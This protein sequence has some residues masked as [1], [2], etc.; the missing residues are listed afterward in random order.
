MSAVERGEVDRLL[1]FSDRAAHADQHGAGDD[2]VT[3]VQL[4]QILEARHGSYIQR[5]E[6]VT[7]V[8]LQ[9]GIAHSRGGALERCECLGRLR[10]V[11][12][13]PVRMKRMGPG[14]RVELADPGARLL[15]RLDLARI[16]IDEHAHGNPCVGKSADH[17]ADAADG[18]GDI[19]AAFGRDLGPALRHQ[20]GRVRFHF[21]GDPDHLVGGRH[22]QVEAPAHGVAQPMHIEILDMSSVLAQMHRDARR[23]AEFS[24]HGGRHRVGFE[25]PT[26]LPDGGHMVHIDAEIGHCTRVAATI[27]SVSEFAQKLATLEADLSTQGERVLALCTRAVES[28]FDRD[29]ER[30]QSVVELDDEVDR[31]DVEIERRSVPM[32]AMGETDEHRIRE[33]LTIVKVNNELE[34]I[35]DAGV[36]IAEHVIEQGAM[37]ERV[38]PTFRVMANSVLGVLRDAVRSLARKDAGLARQVLLFDDTIER[39]KREILMHAQEQVAHGHFSVH[40]AFRLMAVV[41]SLE[42]IADNCTNICEQ[43]IYLRSGLIVRHRPE[44]WSEPEAPDA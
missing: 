12:A 34:R 19:Q 8:E 1:H 44:G 42:R 17:L 29:V 22:L 7:R 33:V 31:V 25:G 18:V 23:T 2:R 3:D 21:A 14:S 27:D 40:F 9:T 39:F 10:S 4:P 30:A 20:H 15:R 43:V 16:G 13:A 36:V 41:K 24:Q 6:P 37:K 28:Y 38:P 35:A 26:R 32:L 5:R 11:S